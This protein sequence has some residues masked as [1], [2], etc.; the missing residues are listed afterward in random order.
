MQSI[1]LKKRSSNNKEQSRG[2]DANKVKLIAL[3]SMTIDHI[4]VYG[5]EKEFIWNY[6]SIIRCI[7]RI[8]APLFLLMLI[9]SIN[10]CQN[11]LR[12]ALRIYLAAVFTGTVYAIT[13]YYNGGIN[14]IYMPGNILFSYFYVIILSSLYS[15]AISVKGI[16]RF[17]YRVALITIVYFPKVLFDAVVQHHLGLSESFVINYPQIFQLLDDLLHALICPIQY[18][19]YS[20]IFVLLGF[21]LYISPS[22]Y[23]QICVFSL[24][25]LLSFCGYTFQWNIPYC[26]GFFSKAQFMMILAIPIYI[27]YNGNRGQQNKAFFY[28]YYPIHQTVLRLLFA[29]F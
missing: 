18:V 15:G 23:V 10:H 9:E 4:A 3:L 24:F 20:W 28:L 22:K 25:S 7:G 13:N 11:L 12:F 8:A 27:V 29:C 6:Y 16:K 26:A 2:L 21:F 5:F 17:C 19:E 1:E 14:G